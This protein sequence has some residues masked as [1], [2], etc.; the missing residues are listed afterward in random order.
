MKVVATGGA[1]FIG[2]HLVDALVDRGDEVIVVDDLSSGAKQQIHP[3]AEFHQLDIRS[4]Q[5]AELIRRRRPD[6][7]AHHAAQMSVSKRQDQ[8]RQDSALDQ[9]RH[10]GVRQTSFI[11]RE[12]E[13]NRVGDLLLLGRSSTGIAQ[14]NNWSRGFSSPH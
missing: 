12:S 5:A 8:S 7:V 10:P 6:A 11:G 4:R 13:L 14:R 2:S 9:P 1:G 3:D